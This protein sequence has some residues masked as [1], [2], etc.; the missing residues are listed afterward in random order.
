MASSSTQ[1]PKDDGN[2]HF[3]SNKLLAGKSKISV[4]AALSKFKT[5]VNRSPYQGEKI[6]DLDIEL[7][8]EA[9]SMMG[10][11]W[12]EHSTFYFGLKEKETAVPR[13]TQFKET[14]T[15]KGKPFKV[16]V[17]L[18]SK[19]GFDD[20]VELTKTL[21]K[22]LETEAIFDEMVAE[23]LTKHPECIEKLGSVT[24]FIGEGIEDK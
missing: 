13:A 16:K 22:I 20:T 1:A 17:S 3:R 2:F 12:R 11:D 10:K 23:L 7:L 4:S 6:I 19:L 9:L 5:L 14:F 21:Q 15:I 18:K 24:D 8:N